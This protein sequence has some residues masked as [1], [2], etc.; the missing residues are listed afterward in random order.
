MVIANKCTEATFSLKGEE[1][2]ESVEGVYSF[3]YMGRI[4]QRLDKD[5]S[6]VLR[7]TRKAR[8]VWGRLGKFLH[9]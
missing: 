9:R 8:Q 6:E 7:K 5:W 1:G 2:P 4:L 3:R